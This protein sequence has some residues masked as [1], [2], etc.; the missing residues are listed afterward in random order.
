MRSTKVELV[1]ANTCCVDA[2]LIQYGDH[3]AAFGDG[4]FLARVE[5]IAGEEREWVWRVLEIIVVAVVF[6]KGFEACSTALRLVISNAGK[7]SA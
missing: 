6:A 5:G 1:V 7:L 2:D 4:A 3:V